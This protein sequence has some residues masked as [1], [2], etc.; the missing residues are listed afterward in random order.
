M[1]EVQSLGLKSE[2]NAMLIGHYLTTFGQ[3]PER[4]ITMLELLG[5]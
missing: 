5:L 1:G 4:D 2:I 3:L